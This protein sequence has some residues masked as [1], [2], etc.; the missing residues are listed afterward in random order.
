MQHV[1]A[2]LGMRCTL[3]SMHCMASSTTQTAAACFTHT[4]LMF[5]AAH[6]PDTLG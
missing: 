1:I 6:F 3:I 4:Q 2:P 5:I